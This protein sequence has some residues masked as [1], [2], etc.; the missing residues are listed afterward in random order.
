MQFPLRD[1]LWTIPASLSLPH[2]AACWYCQPM[3][4]LNRFRF[5]SDY[6]EENAKPQNRQ[7]QQVIPKV[8]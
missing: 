8:T 3:S 5:S 4:L 2:H 7:F 6:A 1:M